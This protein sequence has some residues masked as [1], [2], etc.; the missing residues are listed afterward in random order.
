MAEHRNEWLNREWEH[1]RRIR[2]VEKWALM[3]M[4]IPAI[5]ITL[6]GMGYIAHWWLG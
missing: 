2:R 5:L 4:T 1:R 3:A 6:L